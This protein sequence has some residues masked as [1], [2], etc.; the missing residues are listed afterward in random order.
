MES[1]QCSLCPLALRTWLKS[2]REPVSSKR[3][4]MGRG[5]GNSQP[6]MQSSS[7]LKEQSLALSGWGTP[8]L[9]A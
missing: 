3:M 2:Q 5:A 7:K 6:K 8:Q 9:S 1:H 4:G